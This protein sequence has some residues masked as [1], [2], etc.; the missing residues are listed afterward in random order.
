MEHASIMKERNS[1]AAP[2]FERLTMMS[3]VG[4]GVVLRFY[5]LGA[6]S[7]WPDELIVAVISKFPVAYILKW[8][9]SLEVH[10]PFY[11]LFTKLVQYGGLSDFTLRLPSALAGSATVWLAYVMGR[12]FFSSG[13]ALLLCAFFAIN[14]LH[15]WISRQLRPYAIIVLFTLFA[16]YYL[17]SFLQSGARRDMVKLFLANLPIILLHFI[18]LPLVGSQVLLVLG[19][20]AFG[21][22]GAKWRRILVWLGLTGVSFLPI[23]PFLA[24]MFLM[25]DDMGAPAPFSVCFENTLSYVGGVLNL[26][27]AP[28]A[29]VVM[30][31]LVV[32]GLGRMFFIRRKMFAV[33][34]ALVL[35]PV[36]AILLKRYNT[37][38]FSSHLSFMLVPLLFAA[39]LGAATLL[40]NRAAQSIAALILCLGFATVLF[41]ADYDKLY[42]ED[43]NIITWFNF[44]SFKRLAQT[45]PGVIR[46]GDMTVVYDPMTFN[47]I[48][49]YL[50]RFSASNPLVDQRLG[51]EDASV[52]LFLL[53][54]GEGI[55]HIAAST[56]ELSNIGDHQG[57]RRLETFY[58]HEVRVGRTPALDMKNLP[59]FAE[60]TMDPGDVYSRAHSLEGL[61]VRPYDGCALWPTANNRDGTVRYRIE[62]K[63]PFTPQ[64]LNIN[65]FYENVGEDNLLEAAYRFDDE[66]ERRALL[67]VGPDKRRFFNVSIS[68]D[69]T[70]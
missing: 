26:F 17:V 67:S 5:H 68:E 7:L 48:N 49:W 20:K 30:L 63:A 66:E 45:L 58:L 57:T 61:T 39:A 32:F 34:A 42:K 13:A 29:T 23:L 33:C 14:P 69:H 27:Y 4:V 6:P 65:V 1:G 60:L 62:N 12:R 35:L 46:P 22:T 47:F 50:D 18:S 64:V 55:G 51:P 56:D 40:R 25:R 10:P 41:T 16:V 38:Y 59:F 52:R 36:A 3:I 31:V 15:V 21:G 8:A 70:S 53:S 43:S 54:T 9:Y 11:H 24:G 19:F 2:L 44:G 37:F 28:W